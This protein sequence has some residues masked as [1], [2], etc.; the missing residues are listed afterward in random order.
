M[1]KL[2]PTQQEAQL[3]GVSLVADVRTEVSSYSN[4]FNNLYK[5]I[6]EICGECDTSPEDIDYDI[7]YDT[8]YIIL[9]K[10]PKSEGS[11]KWDI[12][13]AKDKINSEKKELERLKAK[14]EK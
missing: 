7:E 2:T 6:L 3:Y 9:K 5:R 1:T 4:S 8:F 12:E 10:I 13:R 11:L 14:Y